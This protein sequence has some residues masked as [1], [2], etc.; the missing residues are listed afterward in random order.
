M[1]PKI[2]RTEI[3]VPIFKSG[4]E[5]NVNNYRPISILPIGIKIFERIVFNQLYS[6][7]KKNQTA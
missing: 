2:L 5:S 7:L 4:I 1:Y 3:V 6:F